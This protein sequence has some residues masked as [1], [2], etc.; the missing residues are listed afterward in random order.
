MIVSFFVYFEMSI[1]FVSIISLCHIS[2]SL[3]SHL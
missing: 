3:I 1:V 2:K